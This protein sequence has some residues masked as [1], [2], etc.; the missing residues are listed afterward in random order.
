MRKSSACSILFG[1]FLWDG[2]FQWVESFVGP[3]RRHPTVSSSWT[4]TRSSAPRT[5]AAATDATSATDSDVS[6]P[7]DAAARLAFEALGDDTLAFEDYAKTYKAEA[8]EFVKSKGYFASSSPSLSSSSSVDAV[9]DASASSDSSATTT[10]APATAP[11]TITIQEE[12]KRM[13]EEQKRKLLSLIGSTTGTNNNGTKKDNIA[14]MK[15]RVCKDPVL[16]D[17]M[18]KEGMRITYDEKKEKF[19][20][21]ASSSSAAMDGDDTTTMRYYEGSTKTWLNLLEPVVV[22]SNSKNGKDSERKNSV[23]PSP[24]S[25]FK[26]VL[27]Q[28]TPFIP[29]NLRG[30][31]ST[32][33]AT[34]LG[35][36]TFETMEYVP[37]R[38]LFTNPQVSF[39]Y[40][41]GWRQQFQASGFPG[42]DKEAQLAQDYFAKPAA[43]V[44][45]NVLVDMSCATGLFT[46]RFAASGHYD[47]VLGCDY[48][49]S[50]LTEARRRINANEN[51]LLTTLTK[52]KTQ[53]DKKSTA[54]ELIQLDV[55]QIP[56]Q[57]NSIDC[58]HA[59]AAMHCWP[60][61]DAAAAEIYRVLKPNG[62]R[63]F[64]TTFLSTFF[65]NVAAMDRSANNDISQQAFQYF[66]SVDVLR[67]ILIGGGFEDEK[68]SIEVLGAACVVIR[69]EK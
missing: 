30:Q 41:R 31:V 5:L 55:G 65:K 35:D 39:A 24:S 56:M 3:G 20:M 16:A 43:A 18:T 63:Y 2:P 11:T 38:D 49:A 46:R 54:L 34:L 40:E 14:R 64:A 69:A 10:I 36:E 29:P 12:Q 13:R 37:M 53:P 19:K 15:T 28:A 4:A 59:G 45:H 22:D 23:P 66:D 61:L 48:S 7:Y 68:I 44:K 57:T 26:V 50:M 27:R 47:R 9:T 6:I 42:P 52:N 51:Q 8:I 33:V 58:F 21:T 62:G 32:A 17:P 60:D 67:D 1:L 25:I